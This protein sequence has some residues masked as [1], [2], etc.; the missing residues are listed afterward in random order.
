MPINAFFFGMLERDQAKA[1][2]S[3]AR[4]ILS[5]VAPSSIKGNVRHQT[6]VWRFLLQRLRMQSPLSGGH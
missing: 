3:L 2:S 4:S 6:I 5:N 1:G